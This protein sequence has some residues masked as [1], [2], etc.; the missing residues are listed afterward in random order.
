MSSSLSAVLYSIRDVEGVYGSFVVSSQG[1]LIERDMPAVFD[2]TVLEQA[3]VRVASIYET[4][5][6]VGNDIK[7]CMLRFKEH[8]LYTRRLEKGYLCVLSPLS[9]NMPT[10]RMAVNLVARRINPSIARFVEPSPKKPGSSL[11]GSVGDS[12]EYAAV[13]EPT[14]TAPV[15]TPMHAAGT[16]VQDHHSGQ[17]TQHTGPITQPG[18]QSGPIVQ[19]PPQPPPN[20]NVATPRVATATPQQMR[21]ATANK[22]SRKLVKQRVTKRRSVQRIYRGQK[23]KE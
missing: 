22:Q 6:S 9:I 16:A 11:P 20:P 14:P 1:T 2:G 18:Y 12:M 13:P 19:P 23:I 21:A 17:I 5:D 4:F 15:P 3:G 8:K 7:T 10:L